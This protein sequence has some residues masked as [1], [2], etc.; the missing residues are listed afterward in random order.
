AVLYRRRAIA[1]P[2]NNQRWQRDFSQLLHLINDIV[3]CK[4]QQEY[5]IFHPLLPNNSVVFSLLRLC[6]TTST[7]CT[8]EN[9]CKLPNY[10][11]NQRNIVIQD[12]ETSRTSDDEH[13]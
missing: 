7:L 6:Y 12:E 11:I 9:I 1:R 5:L 8:F 3:P 4:S 10:N 13:F 2:A